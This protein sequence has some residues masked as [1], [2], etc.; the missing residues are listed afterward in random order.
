MI[1][2]GERRNGD[3][4]LYN[5]RR[6]SIGIRIQITRSRH[7]RIAVHGR[8]RWSAMARHFSMIFRTIIRGS[9][10]TRSRLLPSLDLCGTRRPTAESDRGKRVRSPWGGDGVRPG[11][12]RKHT[13]LRASSCVF[14]KTQKIKYQLQYRNIK[15]N[16]KLSRVQL[17]VV[18]KAKRNVEVW[19]AFYVKRSKHPQLIFR[20]IQPS[21][22][23]MLIVPD[24]KP[25][26]A[27]E[28]E[29]ELALKTRLAHVSTTSYV[30]DFF[31]KTIFM[32]LRMT[33]HRRIQQ[34]HHQHRPLRQ[35]PRPN[36][37]IMCMW[38]A[39][40]IASKKLSQ[41]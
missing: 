36:P 20:P 6:W 13:L 24:D 35:P 9:K 22:F 37:L 12:Y 31:N 34:T 3:Q 4:D 29:A 41:S 10:L 16:E 19:R 14:S 18:V 40:M 11:N 26:K 32:S 17:Q 21:L 38:I 39:K 5:A 23:A 15:E 27:E 7:R 28:A 25:T 1:I 33:R 30:P 8:C 2:W